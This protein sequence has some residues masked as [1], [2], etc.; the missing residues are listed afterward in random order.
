MV[1]WVKECKEALTRQSLEV[2]LKKNVEIRIFNGFENINS[3]DVIIVS[4]KDKEIDDNLHNE[5][6]IVIFEEIV[7]ELSKQ[8]VNYVYNNFDYYFITN[9]L[10]EAKTSQINTIITGSSYGR[11]GVNENDMLKTINLSL[12]SQDLYYSLKGI[13]KV[14][15]VDENIKN[16]VIC[17]GYY[18]FY[19]D[20]SKSKEGVTDRIS[21]VYLPIF[22]DESYHNCY[23]LSK[24]S[25]KLNNPIFDLDTIANIYSCNEYAKGYYNSTNRKRNEVAVRM[26]ENEN[27][28]WNQITE[29]EKKY[30]GYERAKLHNKS[31][32][33]KMTYKENMIYFN[34]LVNLC[35]SKK[36]NLLFVITPVTRYYREYLNKQYKDIFYNTLNMADGNIHLLD[37][38]EDDYFNEDDF[39]DTDHLSDSGAE[40]L[41]EIINETLRNIVN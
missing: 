29:D 22:G 12:S 9:A 35:S 13:Q 7:D 33:R 19:S 34:E 8:V 31:I 10:N 3:F 39:I 26:W 41:T 23:L 17:C 14:I 2:W 24:Q 36:I 1:V 21:K 4:D 11:V 18:Y 25:E 37:L 27:L 40:K 32:K 16:I 6:N 20:F 28:D 38:Y 30:S 15:E 5:Y